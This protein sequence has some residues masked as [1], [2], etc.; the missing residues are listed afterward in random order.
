[1]RE[2]HAGKGRGVA[3][4][5]DPHGPPAHGVRPRCIGRQAQAQPRVS[6]LFSGRTSGGGPEPVHDADDGK[7]AADDGRRVDVEG[8]KDKRAASETGSKDGDPRRPGDA[9]HM[10]GFCVDDTGHDG[11]ALVL[12]RVG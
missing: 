5:G 12:W 2:N 9:L 3:Q 4:H 11:L 10:H 8:R 6:Q 1:V 7:S